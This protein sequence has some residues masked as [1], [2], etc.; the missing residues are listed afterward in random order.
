M[1]SVVTV[2]KKEESLVK[3]NL[4]KVITVIKV[5][6][7]LMLCTIFF[8][9]IYQKYILKDIC[10]NAGHLNNCPNHLVLSYVQ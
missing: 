7:I 1:T 5:F 4:F 9:D 2:I 6:S 3:L 8:F 10:L